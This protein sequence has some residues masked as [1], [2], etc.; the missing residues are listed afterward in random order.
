MVHP[1]NAQRRSDPWTRY[2]ATGAVSS[3]PE[4]YPDPGEG[5]LA[6]VW[7]REL[8][9]LGRRA[10]V[11]D[12]GCGAGAV[13]LLAAETAAARGARWE[14]HGIDAAA[15][16]PVRSVS[17]RYRTVVSAVTFHP[18]TSMSSTPFADGYFD[19]VGGQFA[20]EYGDPSGV[21]AEVKRVLRPA[22][23]AA[24][25]IHLQESAVV[26]TA[27]VELAQLQEVLAP[28]AV[29]D[30]TVAVLE[31]STG[32][33][34]ARERSAAWSAFAREVVRL[35]GIAG[36][37]D[38][39]WPSGTLRD[40][41]VILRD[42]LTGAIDEVGG[43]ADPTCAAA[44]RSELMDLEATLRD[45]SARLAELLSAAPD[46]AGLQRLLDTAERLGLKVSGRED[47]HDPRGPLIAHAVALARE[48]K[49]T[50]AAAAPTGYLP[51]WGK[52][53]ADGYARSNR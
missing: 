5:P 17:A 28:G 23:R 12:L 8:G 22:W 7:R 42:M 39:R 53:N 21:L 34:S 32:D 45:R 26:G 14:V 2:W 29:L 18:A 16:D 35:D 49:D 50:P 46:R 52:G 13:A 37:Q 3:L 30:L 48:A 44:C 6:V 10:R 51:D 38:A 40:V 47:L 19:L 4:V 25:I 36:R 11:L 9:A 24:F 31:V 27:R 15:I 1:L 41:P 43:A 33:A 20:L